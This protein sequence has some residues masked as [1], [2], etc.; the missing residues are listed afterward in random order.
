MAPSERD[1]RA[2]QSMR[3]ERLDQMLEESGLTLKLLSLVL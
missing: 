3:T 1:G 2:L